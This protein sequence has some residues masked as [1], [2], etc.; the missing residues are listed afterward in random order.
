[1]LI[2]TIFNVV[3]IIII[4]IIIIITTIICFDFIIFKM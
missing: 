3:V 1:M 4:I 2:I